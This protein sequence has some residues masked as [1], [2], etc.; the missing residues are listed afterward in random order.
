MSKSFAFRVTEE[1]LD[2]VEQLVGE[3]PRDVFTEIPF[4]V[5]TPITATEFNVR[6]M[7]EEEMFEAFRDNPDLHILN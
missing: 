7:S 6:L 3:D 5:M 2:M 1:Y 4:M